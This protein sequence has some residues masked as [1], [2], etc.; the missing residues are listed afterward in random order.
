MNLFFSYFRM[1]VFLGC[2]L[3]GM[4]VPAFVDQYGKSLESHLR[5]SQVALQEF[6]ADADRYFNGRLEELIAHYIDNQDQIFSDGGRSIQSIH[7]RN[8]LLR[9]SFERF[10]RNAWSAYTQ[11]LFSPVADV[12]DEVR[13]N[14]SYAVQLRPGAI[15][16]G[17]VVGLLLTFGLELVVRILP[18][19]GRL[20][21]REL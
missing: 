13:R 3:V 4:Q 2:T 19:A 18:S 12:R 16:F 17:L 6:Q 20:L 14:H 7:E 9:N 1:F 8:R 10:H 21:V 5:E 11:A 15:T